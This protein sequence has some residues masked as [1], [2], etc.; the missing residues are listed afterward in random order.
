MVGGRNEVRIALHFVN[1]REPN[2]LD[3]GKKV[4]LN[5]RFYEAQMDCDMIV[6]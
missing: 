6:G 4:L 3:L 2:R 5:E 1:H